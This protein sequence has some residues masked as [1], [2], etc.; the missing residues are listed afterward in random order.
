[1]ICH[2]LSCPALG[3]GS[4]PTGSPRSAKR[5]VVWRTWLACDRSVDQESCRYVRSLVQ[6]FSQKPYAKGRQCSH[7]KLPRDV[8]FQELASSSEKQHYIT[9]RQWR[10]TD[11][12]DH[13][14]S[15][16]GTCMSS[17]TLYLP[18]SP[19]PCPPR[20]PNLCP[21]TQDRE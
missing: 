15:M 9:K 13:G 2:L 8:S 12:H 20:N 5:A 17:E 1:M 19:I 18:C 7:R 16:H 10:Y 11:L 21:E 14:A 4:F 3:D 6:A